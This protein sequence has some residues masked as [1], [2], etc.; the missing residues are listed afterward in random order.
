MF[1]SLHI[2]ATG[3]SAQESQ[4][5]TISNNLANSNTVG[6]K[7]QRADF[8]DLVYQTIR[9]PGVQSGGANMS[10]TG[11]QVGSGVRMVATSRQF[12]QGPLQSTGN[13]LDVAIEGTGFLVV[14]MPDGTP[15]YTRAGALKTDAQG[16]LVTSEGMPL[17]PTIIIPPDAATVNFA[18]DG[19]VTVTVRNQ[20]QPIQVG[21]VQL[22]SFINPSGL[23]AV[24]HNLLV[25]TGAS[26]DP[27]IGQPGVDGRGTIAQSMLEHSNVEVVSEMIGL[28]TAQRAY[29]VN[30]KVITAADEMLRNVTQM[31]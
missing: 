23:D 20:P 10:P 13:P 31:R 11:M 28:I 12:T 24:G 6:F 2:A 4:L 17:E 29:E 26:G 7:K 25:A 8:Q 18:A 9:A 1:R 15:A 3:M 27:I 22:A 14:Q 30:T 5:D 16:R 19:V 21:Q